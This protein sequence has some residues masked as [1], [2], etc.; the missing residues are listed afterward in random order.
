METENTFRTKTG[1]CHITEDRIILTRNGVIGNLSKLAMGNNMARPLIIYG[2][3]SLGLFSLAYKSFSEG[4]KVSA[5]ISLLLGLLLIVSIIKNFNNSA[6]PVIERE[7][8]RDI[9]FKNAIPGA[10]RAYFIVHFENDNGDLKRRLILLP[11]SLT[12]GPKETQ[13]AVEIMTSR[14]G[15]IKN[16]G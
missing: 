10:T 5:N 7:K 16:I 6:T 1:Y 13:K 12:N 2:L 11:G 8:I 4:E 3:L 14:F 15:E 9:E